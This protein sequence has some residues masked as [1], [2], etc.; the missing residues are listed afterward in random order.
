MGQAG[1]YIVIDNQDTLDIERDAEV[2]MRYC[3]DKMRYCINK[4]KRGV[5]EK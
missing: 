2:Q 4:N 5:S 3:I 1:S